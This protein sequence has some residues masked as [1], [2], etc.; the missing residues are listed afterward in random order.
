MR[1]TNLITAFFLVPL[2]AT[3][4]EASLTTKQTEAWRAHHEREILEEFSQLLAIPNLASDSPNIRRN[5]NLIRKMLEKRGITTQ[6]LT[7][8]DMPPIVVGDLIAPGASRTIAFYAH[9]DG[10]PVDPAKW[11]SDPWKPVMRDEN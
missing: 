3:A 10:Q 9:Y 4:A 5:A 7:I 8:P 11:K 2:W 6:L 1:L